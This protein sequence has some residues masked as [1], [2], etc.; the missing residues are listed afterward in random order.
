MDGKKEKSGHGKHD[1][2]QAKTCF[3]DKSTSSRLHQSKLIALKSKSYKAYALPEYPKNE[4]AVPVNFSLTLPPQPEP[5]NAKVVATPTT[6]TPTKSPPTTLKNT[7]TL[8]KSRKEEEGTTKSKANVDFLPLATKSPAIKT[9]KHGAQRP[10]G[11]LVIVDTVQRTMM[12][13]SVYLTSGGQLGV[14]IDS[15]AMQKLLGRGSWLERPSSV[16]EALKPN[17][18]KYLTKL[19]L[20]D[21]RLLPNGKEFPFAVVTDAASGALHFTVRNEESEKQVKSLMDSV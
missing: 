7:K 4:T 3:P 6:T 15:Y 14:R 21:A 8:E 10:V 12:L 19:M 18:S 2:T 17:A 11:V 9:D 20:F 16:A 5:E 13:P 1:Q